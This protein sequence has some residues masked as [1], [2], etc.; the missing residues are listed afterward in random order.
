MNTKREPE[1]RRCVHTEHCCILHG[2]KYGDRYCPV[3]YGERRQSYL[4][5]TCGTQNF[6][7]LLTTDE[8][9]L[10]WEK[11]YAKYGNRINTHGP[12]IG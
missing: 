11:I 8:E 10:L 4:C 2:C 9:R 12:S 1:N 3:E 7:E 6:P 5:E